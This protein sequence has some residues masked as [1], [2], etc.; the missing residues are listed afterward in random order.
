[1]LA[2]CFTLLFCLLHLALLLD[3]GLVPWVED[4]AWHRLAAGLA[5]LLVVLSALGA[6]ADHIVAFG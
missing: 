2:G 6:V 4:G 1:M 5:P 3:F